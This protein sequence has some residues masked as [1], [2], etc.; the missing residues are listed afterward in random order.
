MNSDRLKRQIQFILE[1][2]KLKD[3]VRRSYLIGAD[4]KE[5]SAE[6]SWHLAV[7]ALLVAEHANETVN[8]HRVVRM[9]LVHDIVEVDSGDTYCYD[10][11][12]EELRV[13]RERQ[14]ADRLFGMLPDDQ[15][16][17]F[18]GLWEEFEARQSPDARFAAA[19]WT[20]SCP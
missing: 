5:N 10:R 12:G 16:E 4:R 6:H 3:V 11:E 9:A 14:A 2:D 8:L 15:A 13:A 20:A 17:E 7:M 19:R 18:R 1:I